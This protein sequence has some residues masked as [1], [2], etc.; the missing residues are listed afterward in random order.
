M[1]TLLDAG[2][3]RHDKKR[4]KSHEGFIGNHFLS[5]KILQRKVRSLVAPQALVI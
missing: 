3:C 1:G 4:E 2:A 5:R